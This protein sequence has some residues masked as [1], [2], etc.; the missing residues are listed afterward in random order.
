MYDKGKPTRRSRLLYVCRTIG[1]GPLAQFAADDVRTALTLI[2]LFQRGA[3]A[4]NAG[5][6]DV[7]LFTLLVRVE[8]LLRF[9]L[10]IDA[11]GR[12]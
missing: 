2:G 10:E 9:L 6:S 12:Q 5:I 8:C 1:A 4:I 7:Q 3:H 11:H